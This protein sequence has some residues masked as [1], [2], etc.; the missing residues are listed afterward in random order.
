MQCPNCNGTGFNPIKTHGSLY[1][2]PFC[3]L[4]KDLDWIEY[5]IGVEENSIIYAYTQLVMISNNKEK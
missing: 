5:I 4:K 3:K 1:Y 2:C